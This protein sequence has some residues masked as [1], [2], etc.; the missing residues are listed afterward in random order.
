MRTDAGLGGDHRRRRLVAGVVA[1]GLV[2]LGPAAARAQE[3]A[4]YFRQNCVSCHTIGGG[5]LTGPDLKNVTQRKD[6]AWLVP[7]ILNPKA[8]IDGGDASA[9]QLA[10]EARG[11][12]MPTVFG[13]AP[14]RVES[15][16]DLIEAESKL[17]RSQFAGVQVSDRPFTPEDVNRGRDIFLG[18]QPLAG[19]GPACLS[20]HRAD[21]VGALGGG[22]LGPDLTRV[23]ERL[24]GR[25]ELAAWLSAPATPTMQPVF[26]VHPLRP[27]EIL[28]LVAYFEHTA[29]E[30]HEDA[31][32]APLNFFLLGLGGAAAGLVGFDC[33]WRRRFRAVRRGL[34][35]AAGGRGD[36]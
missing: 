18:Y 8:V 12:I 1:I 30:G 15:L 31:G 5:R 21:G 9:Q 29:R 11:V 6:R 10:Q 32:V 19:G 33:I 13:L 20:C 27:E 2:A 26:K 3:A 14:P 35:D 7:F 34:V 25:K 28:P 23:Y 36:A 4:A 17:E 16:L 24:H 22:Q